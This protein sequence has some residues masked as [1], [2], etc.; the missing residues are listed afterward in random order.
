MPLREGHGGSDLR[1]T[2]AGQLAGIRVAEDSIDALALPGA[3]YRYPQSSI[4]NVTNWI[5]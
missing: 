2:L 5:C 3:V 4:R 1:A